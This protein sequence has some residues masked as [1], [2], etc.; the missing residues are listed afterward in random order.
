MARFI[1][2]HRQILSLSVSFCNRSKESDFSVLG[3]YFKKKYAADRSQETNVIIRISSIKKEREREYVQSS[4]EN[5]KIF[6][7]YIST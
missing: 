3:W 4:L 1:L 5:Q 7:I 6:L 2:S